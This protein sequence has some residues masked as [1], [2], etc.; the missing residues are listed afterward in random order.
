MIKTKERRNE[1]MG[2]GEGE[3]ENSK[4]LR[5]R[6]ERIELEK[7]TLRSKLGLYINVL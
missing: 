4:G 1:D 6:L 7:V 2:V 3:G 5:K